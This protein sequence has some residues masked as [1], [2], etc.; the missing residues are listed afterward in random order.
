MARLSQCRAAC[1]RERFGLSDG[2]LQL[3]TGSKANHLAVGH[4]VEGADVGGVE[5]ARADVGH[6]IPLRGCSAHEQMS[7]AATQ[8]ACICK[9]G[10]R[11]V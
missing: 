8:A 4:V 7:V 5:A 6:G 9:Q 10:R 2:E 11:D 3:G 1:T